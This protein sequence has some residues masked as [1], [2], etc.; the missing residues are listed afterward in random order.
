MLDDDRR[1]N[2][3]SLRSFNKNSLEVTKSNERKMS[4]PVAGVN[5]KKQINEADR[6]S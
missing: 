6:E 4:L 1:M 5:L 3:L 2:I